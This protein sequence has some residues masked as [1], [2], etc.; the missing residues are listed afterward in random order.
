MSDR[1]VDIRLSLQR[2]IDGLYTKEDISVISHYLKEMD[3]REYFD[4][5]SK[6]IWDESFEVK[7]PDIQQKEKYKKEAIV[8]L[9]KIKQKRFYLP[10]KYMIRVVASIALIIAVGIGIQQFRTSNQLAQNDYIEL[11][12]NK[13]ETKEVTLSDG[14]KLFLNAGTSLR[15][16]LSFVG[17]ER[18]VELDGE[19]YF[20]VAHNAN[21]PFIIQAGNMD[22]KVL[23][24]TF[25]VKSYAEDDKATVS[26]SSGKVQVDMPESMMRLVANEQIVMDKNSGTLQK[27]IIDNENAK[28]WM[29][30]SLS[31]NNT[32]IQNVAKELMRVYNCKIIIKD[33]TTMNVL[34]SGAI[35]SKSLDSVLKSIYYSTGIKYKKEADAIILSIN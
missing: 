29:N 28:S 26:V 7:Q 33:S 3:S 5:I 16:P 18:K 24:T 17:N 6:S 1:E 25:N 35:E 20:E 8:L 4:E 12:V 2:V 19:A 23:G 13:G 11:K 27:N 32:S 31:F 15:Y 9:R 21:K 10:T 22:I 30:G 14:T 34:V